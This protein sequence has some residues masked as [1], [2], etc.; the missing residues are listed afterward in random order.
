[1]HV[2]E[3]VNECKKEKKKKRKMLFKFS[4]Y[5]Y[6]IYI[7]FQIALSGARAPVTTKM[8]ALKQ[9]NWPK[10][11]PVTPHCICASKNI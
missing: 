7:E 3:T 5:K 2:R 6:I 11:G 1:M 4:T 10:S 9:K 8:S